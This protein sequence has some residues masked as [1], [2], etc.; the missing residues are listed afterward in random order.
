MTQKMFAVGDR[1]YL[2][3][4]SGTWTWSIE[5]RENYDKTEQVVSFVDSD[6]TFRIEASPSGGSTSVTRH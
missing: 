2:S 6:N 1:V 3:N 4:N 5:M